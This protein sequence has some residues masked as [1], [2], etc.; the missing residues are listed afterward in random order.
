MILFGGYF[1]KALR[2]HFG[3]LILILIPFILFVQLPSGLIF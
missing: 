2:K 1:F 3:F